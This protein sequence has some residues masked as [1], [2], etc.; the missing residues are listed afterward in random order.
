MLP[1]KIEGFTFSAKAKSMY[2]TVSQAPFKQNIL[3]TCCR[4]SFFHL[5][6]DA[7]VRVLGCREGPRKAQKATF[8]ALLSRFRSFLGLSWGTKWSRIGQGLPRASWAL[9]PLASLQGRLL[10]SKML[11][12]ASAA[13]KHPSQAIARALCLALIPI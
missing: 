8:R 1:C 6:S 12:C 5:R 7:L 11:F 2:F 10:G 9:K 13:K 3:A 4:T